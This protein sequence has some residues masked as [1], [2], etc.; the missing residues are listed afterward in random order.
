MQAE[1]PTGSSSDSLTQRQGHDRADLELM[2]RRE[3]LGPSDGESEEL[4]ARERP[5]LRYLLGRLAPAGTTIPADEDEGTADATD[6][7]DEDADTGYASPIAMS[8]NPS[9]I[10]LSFVTEPTIARLEITMRWARYHPEE[11]EAEGA[12]GKTRKERFY[13]RQPSERKIPLSLNG[14]HEAVEVEAG[15]SA[16]FLIRSYTDGRSAVSVFLV[17]RIESND[18]ARPDDDE[19][20]FQPEIPARDADGRPAFAA[21]RLEDVAWT[22]DP[23]LIANEL[24]YWNR[25]EYAV[26]HGCAVA[27]SA[28]EGTREP[29]TEVRTDILPAFELPRT[30]PRES[31]DPGLDMRTLGG[32]DAQGVPRAKLRDYLTPLADQ[33]EAWI[34]EH[35]RG[36]LLLEVPSKLQ[37]QAESHIHTAQKALERIREGIDL[38]ATDEVARR[39]F[40]FAN[41]AMALQRERSVQALARRRGEAPKLPVRAPMAAVPVGLHPAQPP[42]TDRSGPC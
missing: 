20:L 11:R 27:W 3:L 17:N 35:L 30:D 5:T 39:S 37:G 12:D 21:R 36:E 16:E 13:R 14:S 24:L 1:E 34:E 42:G 18:S 7:D 15:V 4:S 41:R 8:M 22:D 40:C 33:Y 32:Q 9:S 28:S 23:D 19:W 26:G 31:D 38:V 29:A 25:P 10:G 6:A 2:L